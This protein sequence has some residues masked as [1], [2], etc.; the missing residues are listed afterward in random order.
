M[1][2]PLVWRDPIVSRA[3]AEAG[4]G[5][6]AEV[7]RS[8]DG[9]HDVDGARARRGSISQWTTL[10]RHPRFPAENRQA[11][12]RLRA[13][14]LARRRAAPQTAGLT[15]ATA[16]AASSAAGP[17]PSPAPSAAP[18]SSRRRPSTSRT[19]TRSSGGR[20]VHQRRSID[21][22][23]SVSRWILPYLRNRPSS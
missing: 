13:S 11:T 12:A 17:R 10:L 21:Y 9:D 3:G 6:L 16:P 8:P 18:R 15:W 7:T 1:L 19:R 2:D 23:R 20:E 5:A 14:R 4:R 22:Y